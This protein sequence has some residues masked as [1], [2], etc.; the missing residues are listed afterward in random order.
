MMFSS[1]LTDAFVKDDPGVKIRYRTGE[2]LN[3]QRRLNA[4]TKVSHTVILDLRFA[5]D[6]ALSASTKE[7]M[8]H[9]MDKFSAACRNFGLTISTKKTEVQHQPALGKPYT[10]PSI[11]VAGEEL[12]A[13]DRSTYLGSTLSKVVN[14]DDDVN[15]RLAKASSA[16]GRLRHTMWKRRGITTETNLKV[17]RAAVLTTL[18]HVYGRHTVYVH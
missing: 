7:E 5:D 11:R 1:M 16:F 10:K 2:K 17:Y 8:Q 12:K 14:V 13:V 6:C 18:L 3:N 15:C 9:I 4:A